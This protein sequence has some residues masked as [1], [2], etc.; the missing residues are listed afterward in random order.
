MQPTTQATIPAP[1]QAPHEGRLASLRRRVAVATVI[2]CLPYLGL[3]VAWALGATVGVD[4]AA[5]AEAARGANILTAGLEVVAVALAVLLVHPAGRRLPAFALAFPTWV[6]TGLLTPVAAGFLVGGPVQVL[7]GGGNPFEDEVLAAWV[8]LLVY[9][10][11]VL[12]AAL[13]GTGFALHARARWPVATGGGRPEGAGLTR[14]LQNLLGGFSIVAALGFGLQRVLWATGGIGPTPDLETAPRIMY[15]FMAAIGG[16]GAVATWRL[17]RGERLTRPIVVLAWLGTSVVF[18]S[19]LTETLKAVA[20]P[21]GDFGAVSGTP[22]EATVGL[23]V[24]LGALA[25]AVGGA[26]R[27]VEEELLEPAS[28]EAPIDGRPADALACDAAASST[29]YGEKWL[30]G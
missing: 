12:Q 15:L 24:L 25:G 16:G 5:F 23:F 20:I 19:A 9:G 22:A 3:K 10:G 14:P 21:A 11:F 7:T 8:F 4:S 30:E 27:L 17:L 1:T 6:A 26:L 28:D 29:A 18:T 13:L 2:V